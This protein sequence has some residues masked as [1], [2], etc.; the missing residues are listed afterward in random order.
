MSVPPPRQHR[1]R[2]GFRLMPLCPRDVQRTGNTSESGA[3]TIHERMKA[4]LSGMVEVI[5]AA[6]TRLRDF[7][8]WAPNNVVGVHHPGARRGPRA[9]ASQ[10]RRR[11]LLQRF[12]RRRHPY[13]AGVLAGTW[14]LGQT[15]AS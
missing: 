12:V 6:L 5:Q 9:A 7:L 13:L 8:D 15:R 4:E 11:R 3:L 1:L 10:R 2:N 14:R